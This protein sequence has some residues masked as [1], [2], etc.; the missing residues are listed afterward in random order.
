[1]SALLVGYRC[2]TDTPRPHPQ[3]DGLAALGSTRDAFMLMTASSGPGPELARRSPHAGLVTP[4]VTKLDRLA[5]PWPPT[6]GASPTTS[7]P[8]RW[9]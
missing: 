7:P 5:R 4:G 9:H 1:M 3:R 8:A 2:S 6:P